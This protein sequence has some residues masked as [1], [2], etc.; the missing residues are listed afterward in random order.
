MQVNNP[1]CHREQPDVPNEIIQAMSEHAGQYV[2]PIAGAQTDG[3][4]VCGSGVYLEVME[5]SL[6]SNGGARHFLK[7][8]GEQGV[9]FLCR[10]QPGTLGQGCPD[11]GGPSAGR[12][13][14]F[15]Y[16]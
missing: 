9:V 7:V 8:N 12:Y 1:D 4:E 3:G 6:P 13:E 10:L 2:L 16:M 15:S 11:F 14:R 5:S